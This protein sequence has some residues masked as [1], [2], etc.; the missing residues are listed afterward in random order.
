MNAADIVMSISAAILMFY[1]GL[2]LEPAFARQLLTRVNLQAMGRLALVNLLL[3]PLLTLGLIQLI[4]SDPGLK[5]ALLMIAAMPC[6]PLVPAIVSLGGESPQRSLLGFLW[7]SLLSILLL[8]AL[9]WVL[10]QPW[11]AGD[12]ARFGEDSS[13]GIALYVLMVYVPLGLGMA[14]RLLDPRRSPMVLQRL[15]PFVSG[16]MLVAVVMLGQAHW[17]EIISLN[18]KDLALFVSFETMCIAV[19]LLAGPH[20]KGEPMTNIL[21]SAIRNFNMSLAFSSAVFPHTAA[22]GY[23]LAINV[24]SLALALAA[25]FLW[26]RMGVVAPVAT[27]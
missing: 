8:P 13:L 14:L 25:V 23:L 5:L 19:A 10:P 20:R 27:K 3:I 1:S 17:R 22:S 21:P 7:L 15:R 9:V 18:L 4:G 26:R 12:Y 24:L 16:S 11:A 6:A 2:L